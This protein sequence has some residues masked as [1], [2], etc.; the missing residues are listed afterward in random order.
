MSWQRAKVTCTVESS[1]RIC[2][3]ENPTY[4]GGEWGRNFYYSMAQ[5]MRQSLGNGVTDEQLLNSV[6]Y[7]RAE[8]YRI[9][10]DLEY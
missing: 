2:E 6:T 5:R 7:D 10:G 9:E 1:K 4:Y 3:A 8:R